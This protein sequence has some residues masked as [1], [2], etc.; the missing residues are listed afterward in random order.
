VKLKD[1]IDDL[2]NALCAAGDLHDPQERALAYY[3]AKIDFSFLTL[4]A[5]RDADQSAVE[6]ELGRRISRS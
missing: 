6:M 5:I 4:E 1:L 2:A 3:N